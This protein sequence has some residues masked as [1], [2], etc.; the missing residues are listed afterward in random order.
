MRASAKEPILFTPNFIH[1]LSLPRHR[2]NKGPQ[3]ETSSESKS[4]IKTNKKSSKWNRAIQSIFLMCK[5]ADAHAF[6]ANDRSKKMARAENT[7]RYT[8]GEEVIDGSDLESSEL[9]VYDDL[10]ANG[11][12]VVQPRNRDEIPSASFHDSESHSK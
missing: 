3:V 11:D 7:R 10:Y 4:P 8:Q 1:A 5:S 12:E 6:E 9:V 2:K